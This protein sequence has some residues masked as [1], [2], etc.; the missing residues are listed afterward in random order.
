MQTKNLNPSSLL[1]LSRSNYTPDQKEKHLVHYKSEKRKFD[2]NTGERLSHPELIKTSVKLFPTVKRN[3]ELQGY[4]VEILWHPQNLYNTPSQSPLETEEAPK[5]DIK[6]AYA[7]L[8][9]K[10]LEAKENAAKAAELESAV[11]AR[12]AEIEE[13]RNLLAEKEELLKKS[14]SKS[15][16]AKNAEPKTP[17]KP[18]EEPKDDS[19][20]LNLGEE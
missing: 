12:D 14:A 13:L 20:D 17:E 2:P 16:K 7:A 9:A 8:E 18:T 11:E 5:E 10:T 19:I 3:L 6:G 4:S 15:G 1:K